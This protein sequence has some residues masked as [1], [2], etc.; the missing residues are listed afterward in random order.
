MAIRKHP[1]LTPRGPAGSET[2]PVLGPMNW[3][4]V[5]KRSAVG[6]SADLLDEQPPISAMSSAD[7]ATSLF[8]EEHIGGETT[9]SYY[10]PLAAAEDHPRGHDGVGHAS[11]AEEQERRYAAILNI[12]NH[13]ESCAL[14]LVSKE[15]FWTRVCAGKERSDSLVRE[16][17]AQII[18]SELGQIDMQTLAESLPQTLQ[19]AL[20]STRSAPTGSVDFGI[21]S[22]KLDGK[23][24]VVPEGYKG[25]ASI[26]NE[27]VETDMNIAPVSPHFP[28]CE[29][30]GM[31]ETVDGFA[32]EL[33]MMQHVNLFDHLV[34]QG[35]FPEPHVQLIVRQLVDAVQVCNS[36]GIA[37]RDIKLS[38]ITYPYPKLADLMRSRSHEAP[39]TEQTGKQGASDEEPVMP[40]ARDKVTTQSS[41]SLAYSDSSSGEEKPDDFHDIESTKIKL[42]DFGMA[43]FVSK[44]GLLRGRCGTPGYVAPDI[45]HAGMHEGYSINVDMFSV[46]RYCFMTAALIYDID[47]TYRVL[48]FI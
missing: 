4:S 16:V 14:K 9:Y 11:A 35:R 26:A 40:L 13:P 27:S 19:S 32:L 21:A 24:G 7:S 47:K 22:T 6:A 41:Q 1:Q 43:G 31:F 18:A 8:Q 44:D 12:S 20:P 36:A 2:T 15:V 37:H 42:A 46:S 17:L 5:A 33:E 23:D 10:V 39:A 3:T 48:L 34:A 38:N 45:F 28:I 29:I 25:D 30:Y